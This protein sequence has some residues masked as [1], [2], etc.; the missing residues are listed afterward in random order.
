MN[1]NVHFTETRET[2]YLLNFSPDL[3][4]IQQQMTTNVN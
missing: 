3:D 2:P 4:K 1:R